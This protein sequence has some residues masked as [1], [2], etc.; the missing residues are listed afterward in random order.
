MMVDKNIVD[1]ILSKIKGSDII[2]QASF[3]LFSLIKR[4]PVQESLEAASEFLESKGWLLKTE[5][6]DF[7]RKIS[8][9]SLID[10]EKW[11]D[12]NLKMIAHHQE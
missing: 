11:V 9:K 2:K 8:Q 4:Y 5:D 3:L 10:I 6:K 1:D 12:F 7:I